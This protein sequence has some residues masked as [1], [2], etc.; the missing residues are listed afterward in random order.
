MTTP[1]I[2]LSV[3]DQSPIGAGRTARDAFEETV[4]LAQ[5]CERLGYTRYWLAEHHNTPSLAGS[6]PEILITRIAAATQSIRVGSG[7]VML[8][9]YSPL[10]VAE[11]FRVLHALFPGRI[12]LGIGRAPGSDQRTAYALAQGHP[13]PIERFP[14]QL[15][16]LATLL[17]GDL[18]G[19]HPF[20]G[21]RALPAP[22]QPDTAPEIWLLGS[23][24]Q[25]A[26]YA[27][28]FGFAF[29]FAHFINPHGSAVLHEYREAFRPSASLPE[30]RA[31]LAIRALCAE[32][33]AEAQRLSASFALSRLRFERG[34]LAPLPT[35]EE[36][37]SYPYTDAE[38][39]RIAALMANVVVGGPETV[40]RRLSQM[41]AAHD[42]DELVIVT[43]VH[44]PAARQRSYALLAEV[45]GLA[46]RETGTSA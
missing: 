34:Q 1:A 14:E 13:T 29:S 11:T 26:A 37:L 45:F 7:G 40:H 43:L 17:H 12:D 10:K 24:G 15:R 46:P 35:V 21:V 20:R 5:L 6:A 8:Q 31:S 32:T 3:L 25:S 41:A 2:K 19:D 38:R 36:A 42:V 23:S 44:D 22:P 4:Q 28:H 9:H 27:A 18:P 33:D 39:A 16:D 30:P